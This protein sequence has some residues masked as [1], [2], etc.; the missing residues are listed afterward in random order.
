MD[1]TPEYTLVRRRYILP[2][3]QVP[4][5]QIITALNEQDKGSTEPIAMRIDVEWHGETVMV[6][7]NVID[8]V[9]QRVIIALYNQASALPRPMQQRPGHNDLDLVFGR[10]MIVNTAKGW[11]LYGSFQEPVPV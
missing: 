9:G 6:P 1:I 10:F 7:I 4:L 3:T 11:K 5:D 2:V 8:V